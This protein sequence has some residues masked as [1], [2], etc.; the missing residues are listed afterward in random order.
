MPIFLF[1][2]IA[3]VSTINSIDTN[4][5]IYGYY[6]RF[7]G[8]LVTLASFSILYFAYAS[9][10]SVKTYPKSISVIILSSLFVCGYAIAQRFGIDNHLWSHDVISRVFS[11]FGQPNWLAAW[12]GMITPLA[13][14]GYFIF[15]NK[16]KRIFLSLLPALYLLIIILTKSRSGFLGFAISIGLTL[17]FLLKNRSSIAKITRLKSLVIT[18]FLSITSVV[19]IFGTP[20]TPSLRE[21]ETNHPVTDQIYDRRGNDTIQTRKYVWISAFKS[22]EDNKLFGTGPET[23][24]YVFPEYKPIEHN[25]TVEWGHIFNKVHNEYLN[26]LTN[27]G[28]AGLASYLLLIT[29]AFHVF[30]KTQKLL[31]GK[32]QTEKIVNFIFFS[33]FVSIL[34]TNFFGFSTISTNLLM[35]IFPAISL[36]LARKPKSVKLKSAK[37]WQSL[38]TI[39]AILIS[40]IPLGLVVRFWFSDYFMARSESLISKQ[41]YAESIYFSDLALVLSEDVN[42]RSK[43]SSVY[44]NYALSQYFRNPAAFD[45]ALEKALELS[46]GSA[47]DSPANPLIQTERVNLFLQ[48]SAIDQ[49]YM[50]MAQ[51]LLLD[52]LGRSP[53][54]PKLW[55]NLGLTYAKQNDLEEA[56]KIFQT[57]VDL[58]PDYEPPRLGILLICQTQSDRE[59]MDAQSS[60]ILD[61][62]NSE[63]ELARSIRDQI[64]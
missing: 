46:S 14:A 16:F 2:G 63:S 59:C 39:I 62:I 11:S 35:F 48:L 51:E 9:N 17:A 33:G 1:L 57:S 5:S 55:Y 45:N 56:K 20:W 22:W 54:D 61:F 60:Y 47:S 15:Q 36:S 43:A 10:M 50:E 27:T 64:K 40:L 3:L 30:Y 24:A 53:N 25:T 31:G 29:T 12:I 26:Y 41:E 21:F 44:G 38:L 42:I 28:I 19:L 37:I 58:K 34:A 7:N 18:V 32:H 49:T 23:F 13:I 8:G 6:G 52:M 4:T